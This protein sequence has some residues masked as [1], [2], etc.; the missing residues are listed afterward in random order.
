MRFLYLLSA[1]HMRHS[2]MNCA[3]LK[4]LII[5]QLTFASELVQ[6]KRGDFD[7]LPDEVLLII[8]SNLSS[9]QLVPLSRTSKYFHQQSLDPFQQKL[10]RDFEEVAME[11]FE[12]DTNDSQKKDIVR[13]MKL[14]FHP[15]LVDLIF[16]DSNREIETPFNFD[17]DLL[18]NIMMLE[19]G[20]MKERFKSPFVID[21]EWVLIEV[22]DKIYNSGVKIQ[23]SSARFMGYLKFS[24]QIDWPKL[25][26]L[27]LR[28]S[29]YLEFYPEVKSLVEEGAIT[30]KAML[31]PRE[32]ALALAFRIAEVKDWP[33]L[34]Q[35][36]EAMDP[37]RIYARI[38]IGAFTYNPDQELKKLVIEKL[39]EKMKPENLRN[40]SNLL[41]VHEADPENCIRLN[42]FRL[43]D[44]EPENINASIK[45]YGQSVKDSVEFVNC[46][47]VL[48]MPESSV[49]KLINNL[50]GYKFNAGG[51]L[52]S[53]FLKGISDD[54]AMVICSKPI[55]YDSFEVPFIMSP[56]VAYEVRKNVRKLSAATIFNWAEKLASVNTQ[57]FFDTFL[58]FL[59]FMSSTEQIKET[60]DLAFERKVG[61]VD[62][63]VTLINGNPHLMNI[64]PVVLR[65][66]LFFAFYSIFKSHLVFK[67]TN[68]AAFEELLKLPNIFEAELLDD[69]IDALRE[70]SQTECQCYQLATTWRSLIN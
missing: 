20:I 6:H 57:N 22:F 61:N 12:P 46:A 41:I 11:Y 47:L 64:E 48:E 8:M 34:D 37:D 50:A 51:F 28:S 7:I 31:E 62:I 54:L 63:L 16:N 35:T 60:V 65:F 26:V 49:I 33:I 18:D 43:T 56:S 67:F 27:I 40:L 42:G 3:A 53:P 24:H 13:F 32:L 9:F 2:K 10:G 68:Q 70:A 38:F 39:R 15:E 66:S 4:L 44:F 1:D 25:R 69:Y 19:I 5:L 17:T 59:N 36:I 21:D 14:C 23:I 58:E 55:D 30:E 29:E 52:T 45:K